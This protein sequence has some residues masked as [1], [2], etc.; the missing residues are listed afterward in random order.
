MNGVGRAA[1]EFLNRMGGVNTPVDNVS[2]CGCGAGD[3]AKSKKSDVSGMA[4]LGG[5]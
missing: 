3:R 4:Q 5:W 1:G 2:M